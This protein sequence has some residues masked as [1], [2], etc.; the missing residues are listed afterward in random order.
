M[1]ALPESKMLTHSA[2]RSIDWEVVIPKLHNWLPM[3]ANCQT[4][5]LNVTEN[6][7]DCDCV[8]C[9]NLN[10]GDKNHVVRF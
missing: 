3:L 1:A 10:S 4:H 8:L 7:R 6:V 9:C 2:P 5:S